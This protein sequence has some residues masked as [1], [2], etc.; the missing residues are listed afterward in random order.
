MLTIHEKAKSEMGR[1]NFIILFCLIRFEFQNL[2]PAKIEHQARSD[3]TNDAAYAN[4]RQEM[5][6]KIDT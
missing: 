2:V 5:L 6:R 3:K 4:I 1:N